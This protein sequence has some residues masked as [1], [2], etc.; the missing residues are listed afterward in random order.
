MKKNMKSKQE[1]ITQALP[2][3]FVQYCIGARFYHALGLFENFS[4]PQLN[5]TRFGFDRVS[6]RVAVVVGISIYYENVTLN[7]KT[8]VTEGRHLE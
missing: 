7:L 3:Y 6:I 1:M 5:L 4:V 2:N 8:F